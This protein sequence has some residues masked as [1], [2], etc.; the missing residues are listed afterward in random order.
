MFLYL[1]GVV[2]I[3]SIWGFNR[4]TMFLYSFLCNTPVISIVSSLCNSTEDWKSVSDYTRRTRT[5]KH[6]K[7]RVKIQLYRFEDTSIDNK[8]FLEVNGYMV[9]TSLFDRMALRRGIYRWSVKQ[10][11]EITDSL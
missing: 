11:K 8:I 3:L 1:C 6:E 7:E 5:Y 9:D 2:L 4:K 10:G